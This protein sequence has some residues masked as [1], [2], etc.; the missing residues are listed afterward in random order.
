MSRRV[1][2][3][4]RCDGKGALGVIIAVD[5]DVI[6]PS[7]VSIVAMFLV[8]WKT[9]GKTTGFVCLMESRHEYEN[10]NLYTESFFSLFELNSAQPVCGVV[11]QARIAGFRQ[12]GLNQRS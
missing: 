4:P 3:L 9:E 6:R 11:F 2:I 8:V 7:P 12:S 5:E 10:E 1:A